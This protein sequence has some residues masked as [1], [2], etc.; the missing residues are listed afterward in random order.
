MS[1]SRA[2]TLDELAPFLFDDDAAT[3]AAFAAGAL[4]RGIDDVV[5]AT[6]LGADRRS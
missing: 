1:Q 4:Q 5:G 6:V 2:G 3:L